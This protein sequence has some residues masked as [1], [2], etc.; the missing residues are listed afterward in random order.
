EA[1]RPSRAGYERSFGGSPRASEAAAFS[2]GLSIIAIDSG[3]VTIMQAA[4]T[5]SS[6]ETMAAPPRNGDGRLICLRPYAFSPLRG[7][8]P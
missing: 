3:C 4:P 2:I 7:S 6:T 5:P 8:A 1:S